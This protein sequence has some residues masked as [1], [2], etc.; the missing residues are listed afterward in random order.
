MSNRVPEVPSRGQG[1]SLYPELLAQERP[2]TPAL[3]LKL[4]VSEWW[5]FLSEE[6]WDSKLHLGSL[7]T[8]LALLSDMF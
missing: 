7:E 1:P 4:V 8:V 6:G 2:G 5:C 3:G